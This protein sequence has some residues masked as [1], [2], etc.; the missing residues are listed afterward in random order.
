MPRPLCRHSVQRLCRSRLRFSSKVIVRG[1]RAQPK[2][3]YDL[4]GALWPIRRMFELLQPPEIATHVDL[5]VAKLLS[6]RLQ[7][8][9]KTLPAAQLAVL[10]LKFHVRAVTA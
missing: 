8:R 7:R 5:Y 4:G 10:H 1:K 6:Y 2:K 9:P 3:Q